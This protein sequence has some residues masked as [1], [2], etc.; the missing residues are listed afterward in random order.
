MAT[1]I[2]YNKILLALMFI[3]CLT[4]QHL[5]PSLVWW[6]ARQFNTL[7]DGFMSCSA[8]NQTSKVSKNG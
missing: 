7:K 3:Y 5:I 6:R 1:K 2:C 8:V 4:S